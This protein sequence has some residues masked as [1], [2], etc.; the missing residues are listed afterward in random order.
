MRRLFLLGSG[1]PVDFGAAWLSSEG[2]P[3]IN[4]ENC[5]KARNRPVV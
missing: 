1:H 3:F 2:T 4:Y 5:D